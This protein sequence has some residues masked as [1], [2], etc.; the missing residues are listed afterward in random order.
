MAAHYSEKDLETIVFLKDTEGLTHAQIAEKLGR[1][2]KAGQPNARAVMNQYKKAK[3]AGVQAVVKA[4]VADAKIAP[5]SLLGDEPAGLSAGVPQKELISPKEE[6]QPD[7]LNEL[8]KRQRVTYLKSRMNVSARSK[9]TFDN[10][11][12]ADEQ[13]M[14]LE[15]Y[16]S[17]ISE[18]D[19]ITS[20]EEQ[21]LFGA[22]LH[23]V[24]AL[25]AA[26]RDEQCFQK[27]PMSGYTG[28]DAAPYIDLFKKDYQDNM[29]K[30]TETM[31][32][33]KLSREQRLKD[34]QRHGTTF[35]DFAEK[36]SKTDEQA[37]AADEIMRLEELSMDALK[38]LQAN[39]W[40]IGGGLPNN[41]EPSFDGDR[42][43]KPEQTHDQEKEAAFIGSDD[44]EDNEDA[45]V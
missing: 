6:K 15:E 41:V 29:K 12:N 1:F 13:T 22:I 43:K 2:D 10:I 18:E 8:S 37:K 20:A 11:L 30:Y 14:F 38:N 24:L 31:K 40:L 35:L 23:L 5:S 33:L 27:S 9:H 21:Q 28:V 19:S 39:G 42:T 3:S 16:F 44:P 34:L 45:D 32:G 36:Y 25:R 17:V 7:Q 26:A 4:K